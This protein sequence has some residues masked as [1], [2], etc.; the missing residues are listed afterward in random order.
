MKHAPRDPL[1]PLYAIVNVANLVDPLAYV[2]TLL[3]AGIRLLQFRAKGVEKQTCL[4]LAKAASAICRQDE[5]NSQ[6]RVLFLINDYPELCL[7]C[8]A[9]GVHLGQEDCC[10]ATARKLLGEEAIIGFSTHNL[11]QLRN[12]PFAVLN[13]AALGPIFSSNTKSGHAPEV[14]VQVLREAAAVSP[15]PLVA[16]GGINL[17]NVEEVY[18]AGA[19][20]AAVIND[21]ETA[22]DLRRRVKCYYAAFISFAPS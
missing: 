4:D 5:Y 7:A 17:A 18:R 21:L 13:Y 19:A 15:I 20:A 3:R 11:E 9:D 6:G 16:V 12:A 8:A 14:G 10:P 1:P 22:D 2:E